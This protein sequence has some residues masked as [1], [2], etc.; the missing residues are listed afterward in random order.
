MPDAAELYRRGLAALNARR[1]GSAATL[2]ARAEQR[3]RGDGEP[4]LRA[5]VIASTAFLDYERGE[6][7]KALAAIDEALAV[8][9]LSSQTRGVLHCQH[10]LLLLR[11]GMTSE[12][13]AAFD[14]GIPVLADRVE[15]ATALVNRGGVRLAQ[16][17]PSIAAADFEGALVLWAEAGRPDEAALTE[18]NLGYACFG[19]SDLVGALRH[20]D[21]AAPVMTAMSPVMAATSAQDRAE[22]LLAAGLVTEG[23]TALRA[24]ANAFGRRRMTQ[25]RAEAELALART[26]VWTEPAA[27]VAAARAAGMR[28]ARVGAVAWRTRADAVLIAASVRRGRGGRALVERAETVADALERQGLAWVARASRLDAA[29][30]LLRAGDLAGA[31]SRLGSGRP[32]RGAPLAVRLQER[33]VRAQLAAASGRRGQALAQLRRGLGDLHDWQS[34]FGS[35]DLQTNVVGHGAQL[36]MR[37]LELALASPSR[38]VLFEWSERARMLASRIQPVR[39][40]ADPQ[41]A[42]DLAELR[43]EPAPAR[44]AELRKQIRERSWQQRG[45]GE[46]AE[47][48][49][50]DA[51]R[52]GLGG[53][54]LVAYVVAA[55]Q[56]VALVVTREAVTRVPLGDRSTLTPLLGGLM[57]DLDMASSDLDGPLAE[58]VRGELV[59]RLERLGEALVAPLRP[60][61]GEGGVV[62]TPSGVLAGV[63]WTLLPGFA[64]RPV[65]V[66]QSATS[67]L[68][69]TRSPLR[70][71]SVG[72][73]A[74]PRVARAEDEVV[75]AAKEWPSARVLVGEAAT[76][77]AVAG[78]AAGVDVLHVAAHGRHSAESP[79]FSGLA[80]ADGPWFGYDVDQLAAVPDVVLLSACEGGRSTVRWGEELIGMTAAWLHAGARCVIASPAAVG[81]EAA[82]DAL[83]RVHRGLA[84]GVAPAEALAAAVPPATRDR[85]PAPFLCFS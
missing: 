49:T 74:G 84:A 39:A 64:G 18:H 38:A 53:Q 56:V 19:S 66:A 9:G 67:W 81:D 65:T 14:E 52:A 55:G 72:L 20:M 71:S 43:R 77:G 30:A 61:L 31:R 68:A 2:L 6:T 50:L 23:E 70:T 24:A 57:P 82:Y 44:E 32:P 7:A 29:T 54:T 25:R 15:R 46:V 10:A 5:R 22:V 47:P 13:L 35:L 78:L 27:A 73:V 60:Y 79:L 59:C 16:G 63:P 1:L 12:A 4:D 48:V 69:R 41:L 83:V 76:A 28:F 8:S 21:A 26:L 45:S 75:A 17:Q 42:A 3:T 51:L 40:P 62:L 33:E 36:A 37:G 34:S 80:L 11:R 58:V 85:A